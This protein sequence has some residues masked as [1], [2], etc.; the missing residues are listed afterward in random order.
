MEQRLE[1]KRD[2]ETVRELSQEIIQA[3]GNGG[4]NSLAGHLCRAKWPWVLL[5]NEVRPHL[6]TPRFLTVCASVHRTLSPS[7]KLTHRKKQKAWGKKREQ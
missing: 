6:P 1:K 4:S 3:E 7:R 2:R 5:R